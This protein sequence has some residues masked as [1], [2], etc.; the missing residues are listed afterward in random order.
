ME[1]STPPEWIKRSFDSFAAGQSSSPSGLS[2]VRQ[3]AMEHFL[4]TGLP[5]PGEEDWRYTNL[6]PVFSTP[7]SF[8]PEPA[9]SPS[10]IN[11]LRS[12]E[13]LE[14]ASSKCRLAF[15]DGHFAQDLSTV[16]V[17]EGISVLPLSK[18]LGDAGRFKQ[19]IE[20][21]EAQLSANTELKESPL[22][23]L[24][25]AF[26]GEGVF[27][28]AARDVRCAETIHIVYITT[29][30]KQ[31]RF[32]TPKTFIQLEQG[33]YVQ[34]VETHLGAGGS[35]LSMP[36]TEVTVGENAKADL[37]KL[38]LED[39]QTNHIANI[40]AHQ[41]SNSVIRTHLF[42]FGGSTVRNEVRIKIDGPGCHT[43]INGL[44]VINGNQHVDNHT[45]LDHA[46]P[47]CES[48]EN[49]KGIYG[50][51]S[52]GVFCGTIIVEK[53]A[54]KTNAFQSNKTLLLSPNASIDAKPQLK[55]WAD[56]V[57]CTHGA[58]VGQMD[59]NALFYMRSR[60]ISLVTAQHLLIHAFASDVISE[61]ENKALR[62]LLEN[63]L[64]RK[65]KDLS[66]RS[67]SAL[68]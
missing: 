22:V 38:Q 32:L 23:S 52:K 29:S 3:R 49:F 66:G 10:A 57:K 63:Q 56:D 62:E 37:Y 28:R 2:I 5:A 45:V 27:I 44:T 51:S 53:D 67:I 9:Q 55:I 18:M 21:L 68:K 1:R 8:M 13:G 26:L 30:G 65:L 11:V 16:P 41:S 47:N 34:I 48:T 14:A 31:E 60:G 39:L 42:S 24:S 15:V 36:L 59:D 25:T 6:N 43:A 19:E 50:D 4:A 46:K 64:M 12:V 20:L 35:T 17:Q 58:T 61:V 54:Q 7:R 33:A 40:L